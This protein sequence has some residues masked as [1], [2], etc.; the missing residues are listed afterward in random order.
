MPLPIPSV[1]SIRDFYAFEQHVKTCRAQRGLAMVAQW[2]EIPVFY[3][4]NPASV[5]GHGDLVHAPRSTQEL[6]FELEIA[7]IIGT[8]GSDL[9]A[10]D[11]AM[12]CVAGFT[13]YNDWSARDLQRNEMAVGLGPSKGK[14]FANSLGPHMI[15]FQELRD[16]Y[17]NGR[18]K[19][20]MSASINGKVV[21][22]GNASSMYW[23]W[24]QLL[25]HASRDTRLMPGDVIGSGTVGS[26]CI[27]ELTPAVTG[28]W[29]KPNDVVQLEIERIGILENRIAS[30]LP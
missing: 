4:S 14:D 8:Q 7:A 30:R 10:D 13:I 3:F 27:L 25:A 28:G 16:Y 23:T 19:L 9:P 21:S 20:G 26:G 17:H 5:I 24:P 15:P 6:D 18:L 11:S 29:L 2:Y 1:R 22:R 12:D